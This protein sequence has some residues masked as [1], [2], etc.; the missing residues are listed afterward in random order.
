MRIRVHE[1]EDYVKALKDQIVK[2]SGLSENP[3]FRKYVEEMSLTNRSAYD[4]IQKSSRDFDAYIDKVCADYIKTDDSVLTFG[5]YAEYLMEGFR[6]LYEQT[7]KAVKAQ[8]SNAPDMDGTPEYYKGEYTLAAIY[9][10]ENRLDVA[11]TYENSDFS[12]EYR[13]KFDMGVENPQHNELHLSVKPAGTVTYSSF[14][15]NRTYPEYSVF[16]YGEDS[17]Y[18][19]LDATVSCYTLDGKYATMGS[20]ADI[21]GIP[22]KFDRKAVATFKAYIN[23]KKRKPTDIYVY[24]GKNGITWWFVGVRNAKDWDEAD[25][26]MLDSIN[27]GKE[28]AGGA[29]TL[30]RAYVVKDVPVWGDYIVGDGFRGDKFKFNGDV[31]AKDDYAPG[32]L[33]RPQSSKDLYKYDFW[34]GSPVVYYNDGRGKYYTRDE[35]D[36]RKA[37]YNLEMYGFKVFTSNNGDGTYTLEGE[38]YDGNRNKAEFKYSYDPKTDSLKWTKGSPLW[39]GYKLDPGQ[40]EALEKALK[41]LI[42]LGEVELVDDGVFKAR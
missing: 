16:K 18:T 2:N 14:H 22:V 31:I 25:R 8:P 28:G 38:A 27:S 40:S 34:D 24:T 26:T 7:L 17:F 15:A 21:I 30:K 6:T 19:A 12:V 9:D 3:G 32:A 10:R 23:P 4:I 11:S 41:E 1:A 35:L 33:D 20:S 42:K 5:K 39:F 37:A 29:K 36:S 13:L